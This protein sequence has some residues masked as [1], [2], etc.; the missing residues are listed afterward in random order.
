MNKSVS[1]RELE[2]KDRAEQ[3]PLRDMFAS[4]SSRVINESDHLYEEVE[5]QARWVLP[6]IKAPEVYND[7]GIWHLK[8]V[9]RITIKESV[10]SIEENSDRVQ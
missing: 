3:N 9:T 6:N 1:F 2:E 8:A 4:S 10:S 5:P 7:L